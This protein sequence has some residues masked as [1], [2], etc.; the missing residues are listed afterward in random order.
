MSDADRQASAPPDG[1]G[2]QAASHER[3]TSATVGRRSLLK[4]IGAIGGAALLPSTVGADG[5]TTVLHENMTEV[6]YHSLGGVGGPQTGG[7]P[8]SP[9]YGG[10]S[11]VDVHRDR[12]LA[13]VSV[14]T[15]RTPTADH[16]MA[17]VDVGAYTEAEGSGDV[18]AGQPAVTAFLPN[19]SHLYVSD[20]TFSTDGQYAFVTKEIQSPTLLQ[21]T[22]ADELGTDLENF[23]DNAPATLVAVDVSDPH[24]PEVVAR[25]PGHK[26]PGGHTVDTHFIDG[27]EYVFT[28]MVSLPESI[29]LPVDTSPA[30]IQV[31]RFDRTAEEFVVTNKWTTAGNTTEGVSPTEG[32]D[33]YYLDITVEDDPKTGRP[34]AYVLNPGSENRVHVVD[35]TDPEKMRLQ[36]TFTT[37][38][39]SFGVSPLTTS[40]GRRVMAVTSQNENFATEETGTPGFLHLVD[41][42]GV[43]DGEGLEELARWR[44]PEDVQLKNNQNTAHL[45]EAVEYSVGESHNHRQY[46]VVA[47]ANLGVRTF[48]LT[49][50]DTA[51]ESAIEE[52][53]NHR[54]GKDIP[55]DAQFRR[56]TDVVPEHRSVAVVNGVAFGL[57]LDS[58]L[59][60]YTV[61]DA[62]AFEP[63]V[64]PAVD[65]ELDREIA[66]NVHDEGNT[67]GVEITNTGSDPAHVRD[68]MPSDWRVVGGD[69]H[70]TE[71]V[72][73]GTRVVFDDPLAPGETAG[74]FVDIAE[75]DDGEYT[76]GCAAF[77]AEAEGEYC[78]QPNTRRT[79]ATIDRETRV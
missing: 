6:G 24:D 17:L 78:A 9:H 34:T 39:W 22:G 70:E 28:G 53:G 76:L 13:V 14:F 65:V 77:A 15:S 20:A 61:D 4:S 19:P 56:Y 27:E 47:H 16:G 11:R 67:I 37:P 79:I 32:A 46:A 64:R 26:P 12:G 66:R 33:G 21:Q 29:G 75:A 60:A 25:L 40:D 45:V 42:D 72:G 7:S 18:D 63:G 41:A 2:R 68:R 36:A 50:G 48:E 43:F 38:F 49:V 30:S 44:Y 23:E 31:H 58:G 8:D 69:P 74:Y 59:Y 57:C 10:F 73:D 3:T 55:A 54:E 51:E 5:E 35:A 52:I 62:P 71:S 1:N